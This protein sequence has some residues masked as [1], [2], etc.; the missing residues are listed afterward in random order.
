MDN[1]KRKEFRGHYVKQ[2]FLIDFGKLVKKTMKEKGVKQKDL[3]KKFGTSQTYLSSVING[4]VNI[5]VER[6]IDICMEL[7][8]DIRIGNILLD[9]LRKESVEDT[10]PFFESVEAYTAG[11]Y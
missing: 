1:E 6:L 11:L 3:A 9:A 8:I 4:N 10:K 7:E 2:S 5:T